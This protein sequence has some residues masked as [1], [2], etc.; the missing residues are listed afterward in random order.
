MGGGSDLSVYHL[1]HFF[2][3]L[4]ERNFLRRY[5]NGLTGLGIAAFLCAAVAYA[6]APEA[7]DLHFVFPGQGVLNTVQDG[8]HHDLNLFSGQ[9]GFLFR[10]FVNKLRLCHALPSSDARYG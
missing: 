3:G 1:A 10:Y 7:P 5:G 2:P 6:E 4:E 9:A 8:V